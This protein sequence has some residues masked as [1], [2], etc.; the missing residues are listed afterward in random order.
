MKE[1][2]LPLPLACIYVT[3]TRKMWCYSP[4]QSKE[5]TDDERPHPRVLCCLQNSGWVWF[6]CAVSF[7][8]KE[9]R[10]KALG[11]FFSLYANHWNW[12]LTQGL[13]RWLSAHM[14]SHRHLWFQFQ[15]IQNFFCILRYAWGA[16]TYMPAKH[17][18]TLEKERIFIT[19][20]FRTS[21]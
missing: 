17:P 18:Y 5:S 6:V 20:R 13:E 12:E 7:S 10:H 14:A 3:G 15:G 19:K 9:V 1:N 4:R 16:Q 11:F 2:L 8:W 21:T